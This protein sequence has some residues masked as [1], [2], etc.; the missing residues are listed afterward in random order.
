[1]TAAVKLAFERD[2]VTLPLGKILPTKALSASV[3][4]GST[5]KTVEASLAV[6][7]VVEPLVVF[8]QPDDTYILLEGHSRLS[9]LLAS[10]AK[11]AE[12]LVSTDDEKLTFKRCVSHIAPIQAN[13]M[14]VKALDAGVPEER[15]AKALNRP[16]AT[17]RTSRTMLKDICPEALELLKDK[18]IKEAALRLFKHVK[19]LRQIEMAEM[20]NRMANYG[21]AYAAAFVSRTKEDLLAEPGSS[22]VKRPA[23]PKPEDLTR[24]EAELQALERDILLIDDSYGKNVVNLTI[25][26]GYVKKLLENAKVVRYLAAKHGDLLTEFQR[27]QEAASL[28]A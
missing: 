18:P 16:V 23:R 2:T 6:V 27:I 15:L 28:D 12:C 21:K 13:K 24:M 7:G 25:A 20:M 8:R 1:V 19:P 9:A 10:D 14:I 17:I 11:T 26:R 22:N 3:K 4:A 5:Y